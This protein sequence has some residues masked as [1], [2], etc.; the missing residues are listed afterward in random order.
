M[1]KVQLTLL[2]EGDHPSPQ[3]GRG[4]GA[5]SLERSGH[6]SRW[7][8]SKRKG[9]MCAAKQAMALVSV[10]GLGKELGDNYPVLLRSKE[11][12]SSLTSH[13]LTEAPTPCSSCW[14]FGG[15]SSPLCLQ[16]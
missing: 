5:T 16:P 10:G 12:H 3:P 6:G 1:S 13:S 7:G 4:S 14:T 2:W 11:S 15:W 8:Q 9:H